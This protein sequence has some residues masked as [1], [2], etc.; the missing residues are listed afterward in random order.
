MRLVELEFDDYNE[1][2]LA[3][4]AISPREVVQILDNRYTVRRNKKDATGSKQ[5]IGET[6]GGR[7]LTLILV[8]TAVEGRWR[9]ITGWDSTEPERRAL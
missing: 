6:D 4:H 7:V 9:P 3:R 8:E 5:L 1:E 2:E